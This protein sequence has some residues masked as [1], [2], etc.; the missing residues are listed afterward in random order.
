[1]P[2]RPS[3]PQA[4]RGLHGK[5]LAVAQAHLRQIRAGIDDLLDE[6]GRDRLLPTTEESASERAQLELFDDQGRLIFG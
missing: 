1:V 6:L 4:A 5:D 2:D 3:V